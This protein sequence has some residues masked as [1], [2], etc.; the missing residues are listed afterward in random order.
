MRANT[1]PRAERRAHRDRLL[2]KVARLAR[3]TGRGD[4]DPVALRRW[5]DTWTECSCEMCRNPR[6]TAYRERT[7]QEL[8]FAAYGAE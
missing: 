5:V 7:V 8:R 6:R 3:A 1:K 4:G 2:A